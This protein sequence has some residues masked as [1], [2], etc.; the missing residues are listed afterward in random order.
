MILLAIVLSQ[1]SVTHTEAVSPESVLSEVSF[2]CG[3]QNT[4]SFSY[5]NGWKSGARGIV[6]SVK[7]NGIEIPR[8]AAFLSE[9]AQRRSVEQITIKKCGETEAVLKISA[10][11]KLSQLESVRENLPQTFMFQFDKNGLIEASH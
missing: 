7:V 8:I 5:G 2:V 1:I 6:S 9:Q 3:P 4:V 11:M 10:E